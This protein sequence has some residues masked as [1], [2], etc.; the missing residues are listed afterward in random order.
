MKYK[1]L[2]LFLHQNKKNKNIINLDIP[3]CKNCIYF[4]EGI[5]EYKYSLGKC[6][7]F[8]ELDSVSGEIKNEYASTCRYDEKMCGKNGKY[9]IE[10]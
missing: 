9:Y 10:N 6:E 3:I 2:F 7:L 4:K 8:G 1:L 5:S